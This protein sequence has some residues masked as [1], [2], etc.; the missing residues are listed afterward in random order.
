MKIETLTTE[1]LKFINDLMKSYKH[2]VFWFEQ[3]GFNPMIDVI[4]NILLDAK[5]IGG[6][7][8]KIDYLYQC[9]SYIAN[10]FKIP[11][12]DT[13]E[14]LSN[15]IEYIQLESKEDIDAASKFV[16]TAEIDNDEITSRICTSIYD[17]YDKEFLPTIES[18]DGWENSF[19][20][21]ENNFE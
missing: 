14:L 10:G 8:I 1:E 3:D 18:S 21:I 12:L 9:V 13:I 2:I 15:D 5:K 6:R 17:T 11:N 7:Y 16:E 19:V 20:E 4:E